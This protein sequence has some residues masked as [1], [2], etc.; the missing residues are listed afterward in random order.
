MAFSYITPRPVHNKQDKESHAEFKHDINQYAVQNPNA[1]ILFFDESR[2]G[3]HSKIG[4][5]WFIKGSRTQIKIKL[6]FEN[7]YVYSAVSSFD[8]FNFSLLLPNVDTSCM[9]VYLS[10][11]SKALPHEQIILVL[12]GAGWHRS[13]ALSVPT[14]IKLI[15]LPAYSPELNPVERL[16]AYIKYHL[17]RNRVYSSVMDL[18]DVVCNFMRN[19]KDDV[20][21]SICNCSYMDI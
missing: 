8:G 10:E 20:V 4:H 14:N 3:T 13:A 16:W 17:I 6:G 1:K 19:L 9:N 11:L 2:F 12:D 5:G 18:Y 15:Q 21:K 7:F